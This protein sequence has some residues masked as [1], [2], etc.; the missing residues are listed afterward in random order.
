MTAAALAASM[1]LMASEPVPDLRITDLAPVVLRESRRAHLDPLLVAAVAWHESRWRMD[2][3]GAAGEVGV[4]QIH[5]R[6]AGAF[7]CVGLPADLDGNVRCG[8]AILAW[9]RR[10]CGGGPERWLGA[11]AGHACGPSV[12]ARRVLASV[13]AAGKR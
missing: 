7:R 2:A 11:Y 3:R 13:R 4:M 9:V 12:Y 10:R 8:V 1:R 6:G 5:P